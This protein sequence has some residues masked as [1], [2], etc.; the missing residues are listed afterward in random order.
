MIEKQKYPKK[1]TIFDRIN[2]RINEAK[3]NIENS[4]NICEK[5]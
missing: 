2:R 3:N 4:D 5:N 1:E